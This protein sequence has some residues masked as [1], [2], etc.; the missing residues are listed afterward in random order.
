MD[1]QVRVLVVDDDLDALYYVDDLLAELGCYPIKATTLED[2]VEILGAM[3][4]DAVIMNAGMVAPAPPKLSERLN[5][6]QDAT[7]IL[8]MTRAGT[9]PEGRLSPLRRFL[10]HPPEIGEL[11]QALETCTSL[12]ARAP[13]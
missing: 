11:E 10:E 6:V 12:P 8:F 9:R 4:V 5:A 2:G 13:R 3:N 7:P 1:H